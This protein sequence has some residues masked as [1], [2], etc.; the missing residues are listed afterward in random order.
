MRLFQPEAGLP[1]LQHVPIHRIGEY[2]YIFEGSASK[3]KDWR[4]D[5]YR[6]KPN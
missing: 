6:W 1:I 4:A 3:G 5:G 2:Q